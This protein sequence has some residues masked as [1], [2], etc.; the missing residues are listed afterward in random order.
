MGLLP[1]AAALWYVRTAPP[2]APPDTVPDHA[3]A[4]RVGIQPVEVPGWQA[5]ATPAANVFAAGATTQ[6]AAAARTAQQ[7]SSVLARCLHVP[8]SALDGAFGMG[9]AAAQRT[10]RVGSPTYLDPAGDGGALSSVVDVERSA[11]VGAADAGVFADPSLFATCY[12]PFVQAMLPYAGA[13]APTGGY[14]T[15]TVEPAVVPVPDANPALT[16]AAFQIARIGSQNG[17]SVTSITTAGGRLRRQGAGHRCRHGERSRVPPRHPGPVVRAIE[18][19]VIGVSPAV[20]GAGRDPPACPPQACPASGA[21]P[22]GGHGAGEGQD[23]PVGG[24]GR[25]HL[26]GPQQVGHDPQQ[27][28]HDALRVHA[29][30]DAGPHE[31]G[32]G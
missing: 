4:A 22:S 14:A 25:A 11:Q 15:A 27:P 16:V 12:Q 31:L 5:V 26:L 32:A 10:A 20:T 8:A 19:R 24:L 23:G 28:A 13:G 21:P 9:G 29:G 3:L 18:A 17:Q 6:G 30:L 7:A 1:L 2:P